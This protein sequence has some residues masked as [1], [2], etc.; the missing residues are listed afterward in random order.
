[1]EKM[2]I[3]ETAHVTN[4][5]ERWFSA[6]YALWSE[7]TGGSWQLIGGSLKT[8]VRRRVQECCWHVTGKSTI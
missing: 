4:D 8:V 6:V 2:D 7:H 3:N 5:L 1:M